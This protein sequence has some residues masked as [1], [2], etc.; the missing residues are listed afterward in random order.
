MLKSLEPALPVQA[1]FWK[2]I[3]K[4]L[5]GWA[6]AQRALGGVSGNMWAF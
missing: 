1:R 4:Q 2:T 6:G 3:A 5:V